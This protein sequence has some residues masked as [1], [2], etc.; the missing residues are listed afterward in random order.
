MMKDKRTRNLWLVYGGIYLVMFL[1]LCLTHRSIGD[2]YI[3]SFVWEGH[4]MYE[5]LSEGARRI[6]SFS[7]IAQST[8][9]YFMTWGGRVE[10]QALAMW[11]LWMPRMVFTVVLPGA[12]VLLVLLVQWIAQGGQVIMKLSPRDALLI[13][14]CLWSF[15]ANFSGIFIWLDGSFNY[16]FPML[17]LLLFLLP[18]IRHYMTGGRN[19]E[20]SWLSWGMFPLGV[21]A[22][23]SNENTICWIGLFGGLYL[24]HA[25]R[26]GTLRLWMVSGLLGLALGYGLL[27]LAPGNWARMTDSHEDLT[28]FYI[29]YNKGIKIWFNTLLQSMLWYYL[30]R[31]LRKRKELGATEQGRKRRRLALWFA[32]LSWLSNL[33]M[34][35]SPEFPNR[36]LFPGLV[37]AIIAVF[38]IATEARERDIYIVR[39]RQIHAHYRLAALYF[40]LTF[41]TAMY[42]FVQEYSYEEEVLAKVAAWQ[43]QDQM[44]V[45]EKAPPHESLRWLYL[46]GLHCYKYNLTDNENDWKNVAFARFHHLPAVRLVRA[47]TKDE[48]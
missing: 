40:L 30:W 33:I 42:W 5:P 17:F 38:I 37:F 21:L 2:D 4:S 18:Y 25:Y 9:S 29:T 10:A 22:G 15:H 32:V 36:S 39:K 44:L 34:L 1:L 20:A 46:T 12:T 35:F 7:D 31:A 6:S 48:G 41:C 26:K 14:F 24:C 28:N 43:G 16:L 19:I 47:E 27:L 8:Y 11:F 13:F 23:N 45:I 3:Y